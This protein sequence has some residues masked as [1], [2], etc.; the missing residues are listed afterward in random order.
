M[1]DPERVAN[2]TTGGVAR[3]VRPGTAWSLC[4]AAGVLGALV[5]DARTKFVPKLGEWYSAATR[6]TVILQVRPWLFGAPGFP[7]HLRFLIL[8]AVTIA[9]FARALQLASTR[10]SAFA[11]SIAASAL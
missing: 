1:P 9:L 4:G 5:L 2:E 7:D 8:Y 6:L 3:R 11:A 10:V